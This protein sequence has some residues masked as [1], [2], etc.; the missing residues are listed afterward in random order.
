MLFRTLVR[1]TLRQPE[2]IAVTIPAW[3]S[4]VKD[5]YLPVAAFPEAVRPKLDRDYSFYAKVNL[6][7]ENKYELVFEEMSFP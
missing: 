7:E 4:S 2:W 5:V 1:V 3:D 6:S